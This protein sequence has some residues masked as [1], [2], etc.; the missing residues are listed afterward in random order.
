MTTVLHLGNIGTH[1][2]YVREVSRDNEAQYV[3]VIIATGDRHMT[4][5]VLVNDGIT[6][7]TIVDF[8]NG[9]I[10]RI[11]EHIIPSLPE[12]DLAW[13]YEA[14]TYQHPE[15][16]RAYVQLSIGHIDHL[17]SGAFFKKT[18]PA[19]TCSE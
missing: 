14:R 7:S 8:V 17:K 1:A 4:W 19:H 16:P 6:H 2:L 12:S 18:A 11:R 15:M 5:E 3:C 13:R 10:D 9:N